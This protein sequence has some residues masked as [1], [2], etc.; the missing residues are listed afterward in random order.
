LS[1]LREAIAPF[2]A[3]CRGIVIDYGCGGKPYRSL[4]PPDLLYRGVDFE[5]R[6]PEDLVLEQDGAL[7]CDGA[8]ANSIVSFQVLE[9]VTSAD[10]FAAECFRVLKPG[11]TL[12]LTTHGTWPYHPG[13]QNDDFL[14]WTSAGLKILLMRAGFED[15]SVTEVCGGMLCLLQQQLVLKDPARVNRG[16]AARMLYRCFSLLINSTALAAVSL[17]SRK[18]QSGDI[19]PICY[20]VTASKKYKFLKAER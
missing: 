12:F 8:I 15:I 1:T 3:S 4:F 11:G 16:R 9:H 2:A 13:P 7:P 10:F 6:H 5:I 19:L 20:A 14:R 17:L 18:T